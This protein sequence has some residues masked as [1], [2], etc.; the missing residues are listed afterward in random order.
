MGSGR[1][2]HARRGE[3]PREGGRMEVVEGIMEQSSQEENDNE[4]DLGSQ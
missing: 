1:I 3:S 2:F 4:S